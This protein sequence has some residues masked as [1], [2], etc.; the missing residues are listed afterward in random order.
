MSKM[1]VSSWLAI[2]VATC[3]L[4]AC[5]DNSSA[6]DSSSNG[7]SANTGPEY[8]EVDRPEPGLQGQIPQASQQSAPAPSFQFV[9]Q[10]NS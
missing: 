8:T 4:L 1:S 6:P 3:L 5:G 7:S 9:P 10:G 2:A